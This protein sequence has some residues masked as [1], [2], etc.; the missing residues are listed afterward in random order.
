MSPKYY[1]NIIISAATILSELITRLYHEFDENIKTSDVTPGELKV[2]QNFKNQDGR[3]IEWSPL[4]Q[5]GLPLFRQTRFL[6]RRES[7][8]HVELDSQKD[9]LCTFMFTVGSHLLQ[10]SAP[11]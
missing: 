10:F 4:A 5:T 2:R 11:H 1:K 6:S 8:A 9:I 3:Q 7:P